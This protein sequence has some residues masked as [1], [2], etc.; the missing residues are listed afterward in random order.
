MQR[1]F[2]SRN[3]DNDLNPT[4][5]VNSPRMDTTAKEVELA[6]REGILPLI[7]PLFDKI[8]STNFRVSPDPPYKPPPPSSQTS[9]APWHVYP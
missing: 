7:K 9:P 4:Q 5:Q 1:S 8:Q 2:G 6:K 3:D